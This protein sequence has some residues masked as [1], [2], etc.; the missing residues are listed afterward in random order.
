MQTVQ[1]SSNDVDQVVVEIED[2]LIGPFGIAALPDPPEECTNAASNDGVA[3]PS[4]DPGAV[5]NFLSP[6]AEAEV[7]VVGPEYASEGVVMGCGDFS[8]TSSIH[9]RIT[10]SNHLVVDEWIMASADP[11]TVGTTSTRMDVDSFQLMLADAESLPRIGRYWEAAPGTVL[12][13]LNATIEGQGYAVLARNSD[14]MRFFTVAAGVGQC[15]SSVAMCTVSRQFKIEY[16]DVF[17]DTW[18]MEVPLITWRP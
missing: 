14:T 7:C 5:G 1:P 6:V 8:E 4:T 3:A 17:S 12:F 15:P 18:E 9:R 10:A 2:A 13:H 16:E 11:S